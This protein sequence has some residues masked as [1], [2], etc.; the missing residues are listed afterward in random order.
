MKLY[1]DRDNEN[2]AGVLGIE[3]VTVVD[4]ADDEDDGEDWL[5]DSPGQERTEGVREVTVSDELSEEEKTEIR[6]LPDDFED[7]LLDVPG[8]TT[9]G[10]HDIKLTTNEPVRTNPYPLP[11]VSRD[12]VCKE[13]QKMIEAG[14]IEPSILFTHSY[15]EEEG[16]D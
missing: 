16:R 15:C 8:V 7:V 6:T 5:C 1:I 3:G 12:T 10:V 9:L 13:V 14:V 4:L 11:F 2:D